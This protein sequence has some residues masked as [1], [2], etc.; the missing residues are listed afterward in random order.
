MSSPARKITQ[1]AVPE[2]PPELLTYW[3][4]LKAEARKPGAWLG[5]IER[6]SDEEFARLKRV[7]TRIFQAW[8]LM[9][10]FLAPLLWLGF[11]PE[12]RAL[13]ESV[14]QHFL[15]PSARPGA[16][17]NAP[18]KRLPRQRP[19]RPAKPEDDGRERLWGSRGA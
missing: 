13:F 18:R 16:E 15:K 2:P 10:L 4:C 5:Q 9:W 3:E 12:R 11:A 8:A 1:P 14:H 6:V 17:P 19:A 7:R